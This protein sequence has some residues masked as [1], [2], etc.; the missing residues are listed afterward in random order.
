[1]LNFKIAP[2]Y[3]SCSLCAIHM[4]TSSRICKSPGT[5]Y[6][7]PVRLRCLNISNL[8]DQA[9]GLQSWRI[10]WL[11]INGLGSPPWAEISM[12]IWPMAQGYL[13]PVI[14]A[15]L[16][17]DSIS[18]ASALIWV[19][20]DWKW[21]PQIPDWFSWIKGGDMQ[22]Q[23]RGKDNQQERESTVQEIWELYYRTLPDLHFERIQSEICNFYT[24]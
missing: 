19:V 18:K 9:A 23:V 17:N 24:Q 22:W 8:Q 14:C 21:G 16:T 12:W 20:I 2:W 6:Y 13:P 4:N 15:D 5:W 1:M 11:L 10:Q 7:P 3:T